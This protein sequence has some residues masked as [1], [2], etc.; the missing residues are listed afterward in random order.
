MPVG[1]RGKKFAP[2]EPRSAGPGE[3][4]PAS[5]PEKKKRSLSFKVAFKKQH[6]LARS[7]VGT[8]AEPLPKEPKGTPKN[9][10]G[11]SKILFVN[12]T[13]QNT[14]GFIEIPFVNLAPAL[15]LIDFKGALGP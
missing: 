13:L 14:N 10:N 4:T 3:A 8:F 2:T 5:Q 1:Q 12:L 6:I 9:T 15:I 7:C 11:I